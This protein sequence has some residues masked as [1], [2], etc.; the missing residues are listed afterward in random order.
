M[1][2]QRS[3]VCRWTKTGKGHE[4]MKTL[5]GKRVTYKLFQLKYEAKIQR[6]RTIPQKQ[7]LFYHNLYSGF[8]AIANTDL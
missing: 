3:R 2:P 8:I 5:V 1:R 6:E 4:E 7:M